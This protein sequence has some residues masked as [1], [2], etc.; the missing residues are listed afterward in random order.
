ME[1]STTNVVNCRWRSL[2]FLA[3]RCTVGV[4][5]SFA[6]TENRILLFLRILLNSC[7]FI[8]TFTIQM[9]YFV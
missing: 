6:L 4:S 3:E 9:K 5:L 1:L 8:Y 2:F 7:I